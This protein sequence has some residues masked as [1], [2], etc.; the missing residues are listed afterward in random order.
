[1]TLTKQMRRISTIVSLVP[2]KP[3]RRIEITTSWS[4]LAAPTPPLPPITMC[5]SGRS[6]P[7]TTVPSAPPL[8]PR[9]LESCYSVVEESLDCVY[10]HCRTH[11]K[12]VGP[13]EI[14]VVQA[15]AF[16]ALIDLLVSLVLM[17]KFGKIGKAGLSSLSN[18][19]IRFWQFQ[20]KI[21]E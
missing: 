5:C 18:R 20:T 17:I 14:R 7:P 12:S 15:G 10:R 13:L 2:R 6:S 19:S 4:T 9:F 16:G 1:M 8:D 11:D 21:G 3:W